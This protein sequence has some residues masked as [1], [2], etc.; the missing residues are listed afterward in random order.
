MRRRQF[1]YGSAASLAASAGLSRAAPSDTV[2]IGVIGLRGMGTANLNSM[3]K[4]TGTRCTAVCDVDQS[5]LE[6]RA[7]KVA[8]STNHTPRLYSDYRALLDDADVDVVIIATPDHWHCLQLVDAID[9]GKHAYVEKPIA[10]SI[11][12]CQAMVAAH[13]KSNR[14]VQVGQW[15]RSAPHFREAVE[16]VHSGKLGNIRTVKTWAYINW[17]KMDKAPDSPTP[18]GVDYNMWLGPAPERP[19]NKNRF[20]FH[21]R[22]FWDYAGGLM[23]DWGVHLIDVALW[24]MQADGPERVMSTGGAFAYEDSGME[25]PDTQQAVYEFPDFTLVWDHAVGIGLGPFQRAHGIAF[26]GNNGTLVVDREQWQIFP[27]TEP[28]AITHKMPSQANRR[29]RPDERGLDLH[30]KNF[31]N[32]VREGERLN[33]DL[34]TGAKAAINAHLGNIAYQTGSNLQWDTTNTRFKQSR[35]AN[36]MLTPTYRRPWQ[37]P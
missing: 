10:N 2:N 24:G 11:A 12:E 14:L 37:L 13:E 28:G 35:S 33:C 15:Q 8:S 31:I 23:T 6:D 16:F 36:R 1:I 19:F 30:T 20:H 22:W 26:V 7:G 17:L 34:Q 3:L 21:F 29:A 25:T 9:A 5:V 27:E 32:A 18:A 4:V